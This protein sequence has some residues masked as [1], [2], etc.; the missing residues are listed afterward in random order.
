MCIEQ[1]RY[2]MMI[3]LGDSEELLLSGKR[4]QQDDILCL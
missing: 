2:G 4:K 3:T 1:D